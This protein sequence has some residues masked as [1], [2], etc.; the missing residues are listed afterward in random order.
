MHF[1]LN[2]LQQPSDEERQ[3]LID[4]FPQVVSLIEWAEQLRQWG[5]APEQRLAIYFRRLPAVRTVVLGTCG[6]AGLVEE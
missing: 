6:S 3:G 4:T 5:A 1:D 2:D